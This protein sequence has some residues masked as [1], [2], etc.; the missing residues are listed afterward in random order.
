M[1][2]ETA[3]IPKDPTFEDFRNENGIVFW[4]ASDL[5]KMLGYTSMKSFHKAIERA[6]R[7]CMSLGIPHYEIFIPEIRP[8]SSP[9]EQDFKLQRFACYLTVMN[10]DPKK[11]EV[12]A[13]Q[14]YFVEQT[15]RFELQNQGIN[16]MERIL[17]R[18]E[19]KDGNKSL[20]GVA[21][22]AGVHDYARF[23]NAGYLGLYNMMNTSLAK[24]RNV[25]PKQLV[26]CMGRTELAANLFRITQTEERIKNFQV[27]GQSQLEKTHFDV[28]REVREMVQTNTGRSP[29]DL[30]VESQLGTVQKELRSGYRKMLKEDGPKTRSKKADPTPK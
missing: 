17:I 16:E 8:G 11:E 12:A 20:A 19:I 14:V 28:G 24:R 3:L 1:T 9:G 30:P 18:D 4:W 27:K 23:Q 22:S 7:A 13:A 10:A 29:E 15:R 21:K 25:D 6:I 26:E 5:M 2:D